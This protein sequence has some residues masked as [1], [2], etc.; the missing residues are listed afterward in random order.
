MIR[1]LLLILLALPVTQHATADSNPLTIE[2]GAKL[3]ERCKTAIDVLGGKT[4]MDTD[5]KF[6]ASTTCISFID[7]F[8]E[9]HNVSAGLLAA[10]SKGAAV[11]EQDII[12]SGLYCDGRA[13][14]NGDVAQ[15]VVTFL[16]KNPQKR[17]ARPGLVL[18]EVLRVLAPC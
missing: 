8:R 15:A 5:E 10:R 13:V 6:I 16:E 1:N 3:Y 17:Q 4:R 14:S 7:G 12:R 2:P 11:T 9:G 18:V